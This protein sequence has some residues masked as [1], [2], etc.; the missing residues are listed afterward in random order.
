MALF[1]YSPDSLLAD[2]PTMYAFPSLNDVYAAWKEHLEKRGARVKLGTEVLNVKDRRSSPEGVILCYK[3]SNGTR[4]Q[5]SIEVESFDELILA[6]D[7]DSCLKILSSQAS[8]L[9]KKVLGNVKYFYDISVT[10]C[11]CEYMEKA[12]F[13]NFLSEQNA[14]RLM[15]LKSVL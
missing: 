12:C 10:H 3:D 13:S 14:F 5:D 15:I 2:I 1:E 11:D 6:V 4:N 7:A 9:E 8:W